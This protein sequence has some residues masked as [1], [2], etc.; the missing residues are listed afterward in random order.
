[1]EGQTVSH[2][3]ILK[4]IGEGGMGE[5]YLAEDTTL[6][7]KVA[8]K[9]LPEHL[10]QEGYFLTELIKNEVES[11]TNCSLIVGVGTPRARLGD[12]NQS[13][14]EA[15][16]VVQNTGRESRQVKDNHT[17]DKAE[18]LKL[19][20]SKLEGFL[21]FGTEADFETFFA[22]YIQPLNQTALESYLIKNYIFMQ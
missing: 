9:F 14:A 5:V 4:K 19:D 12:I 1:M 18:L 17:A 13:L 2:Y 15:M 6:R 7:R 20:K 3:R 11:M 16:A 22:G 8:L 21:K 10:Q